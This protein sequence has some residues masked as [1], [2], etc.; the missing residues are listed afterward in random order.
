MARTLKSDKKEERDFKVSVFSHFLG[1]QTENS[2][3][4][5]KKEQVCSTK[6]SCGEST[7]EE[8]GAWING[9]G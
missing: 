4:E 1:K 6:R 7:A 2:Q 5:G 9:D 8:T 3:I